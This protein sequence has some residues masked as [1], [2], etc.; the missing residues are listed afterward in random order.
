LPSPD[1]FKVYDQYQNSATA[2]Y[3]DVAPG[4][5]KA[6]QK[7]SV[8]SI[9]YSVWLTNGQQIGGTPQNKP[10]TFTEGSSTVIPGLEE[11]IYGMKQ[12]GQRRLIV[13]PKTAFGTAGK[14]PVPPN[15]VLIFDVNLTGVS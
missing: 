6:V 5:G 15:A 2:M 3:I 12:G 14:S 8:V 7:G 9:T 10:Y 4:T 13:P 1:G 11:A